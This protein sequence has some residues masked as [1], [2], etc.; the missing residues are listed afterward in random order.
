MLHS[1]SC[2]LIDHSLPAP[3]SILMPPP[4]KRNTIG[5]RGSWTIVRVH[6]RR[7]S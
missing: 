7:P 2:T 5:M 1:K 6:G 3:H 4:L